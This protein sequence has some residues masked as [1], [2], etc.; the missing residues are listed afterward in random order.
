MNN[1]SIKSLGR[2]SSNI[3]GP[4]NRLKRGIHP[5]VWI[6]PSIVFFL[7]FILFP[8][9]FAL[10]ISFYDWNGISRNIF[11]NFTGISNY[12]KLFHDKYF[13]ISLKNTGI[14][15]FGVTIIQNIFAFFLAVFIFFGKFKNSNIVRAIIFYPSIISAVVVALVW[16][17]ILMSDGIINTLLNYMGLAN[18]DFLSSKVLVMWV[19]TFISIW[20]WTGYNLVILYAGLQSINLSVVEAAYVDGVNFWGL[21]FKVILPILK[22][23]IWLSVILN[24]IGGFR[25]FDIVYILTRGGPAHASEVMTTYMYYN[26]FQAAGPNDMGY[27]SAIA[28]FLAFIIIIFTALRFK[29]VKE[30]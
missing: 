16:R 13:I 10:A 18:I 14:L 24:F 29:Y 27:A 1:I 28:M 19:I 6:S 21:I 3:T 23:T 8:L 2:N 9:I 4:G 17:Q 11:A 20:Q 30:S 12:A 26:S 15:V 25:A 7:A 5:V 22:P